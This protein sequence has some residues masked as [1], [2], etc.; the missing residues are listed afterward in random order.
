MSQEPICSVHF[1]GD[2]F[3]ILPC[4]TWYVLVQKTDNATVIVS[5]KNFPIYTQAAQELKACITS[6]LDD[7]VAP[8]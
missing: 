6:W 5:A 2:V 7:I 8:Q 4:K 1:M 3:E